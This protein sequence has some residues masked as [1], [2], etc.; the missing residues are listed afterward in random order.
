MTKARHKRRKVVAIYCFI[1]C[2]LLAVGTLVAVLCVSVAFS[3]SVSLKTLS[4]STRGDV[5]CFFNTGKSCT[6]CDEDVRRCPEWTE[7]DAASVL[8]TQGKSS[9]TLAA[10][11][12]VYALGSIQFGF[13]I[14]KHISTYQIEY[15]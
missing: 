5:A 8:E 11:F 2:L 1:G 10:I 12:T 4:D 7:Q 15:V 6:R 14:R 3:S 9:A 13:N